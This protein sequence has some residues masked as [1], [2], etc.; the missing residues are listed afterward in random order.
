MISRTLADPGLRLKAPA[1]KL[2]REM[3]FPGY[4]TVNA[5]MTDYIAERTH[6]ADLMRHRRRA[7]DVSSDD[8]PEYHS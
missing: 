6:D 8:D 2:W 4:T 5:G 7:S 3:G 1:E